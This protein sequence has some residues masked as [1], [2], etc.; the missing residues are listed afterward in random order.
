[1]APPAPVYVIMLLL[2][3]L[4]FLYEIVFAAVPRGMLLAAISEC[5]PI[6]DQ[7][8]GFI[9]LS[10]ALPAVLRVLL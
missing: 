3:L 1:M 8:G 4:G 7:S 9:V 5:N 2:V 6:V 10:A